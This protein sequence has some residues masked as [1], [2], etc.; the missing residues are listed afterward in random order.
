MDFRAIWIRDRLCKILGVFEPRYI[1]TVLNELYDELVAF[2]DDA[3]V[4]QRDEHKRIL[5]AYRTFYERL[6]EEKVTAFEPAT[7]GAAQ[8]G[9]TDQP[10]QTQREKKGK[11]VK[12]G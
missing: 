5:F 1:D 12:G 2:L 11:K 10:E 8:P 4:D 6:I 9:G 7:A 3:V